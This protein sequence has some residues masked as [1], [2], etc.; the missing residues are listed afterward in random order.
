MVEPDGP[1]CHLGTTSCFNNLVFQSEERHEF[2]YQDLMELIKGRKIDK[3]ER[4]K[5][6][7][8]ELE[9]DDKLLAKINEVEN[10]SNI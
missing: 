5:I 9:Q 2:S 10:E 8:Y 4:E 6:D 1:A 3:K 7:K